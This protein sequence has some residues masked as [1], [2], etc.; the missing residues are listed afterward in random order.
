M[1]TEF[2]P[3]KLR[4]K[5]DLV[6]YP[7]RAE[8]LGKYD[9]V[10]FSWLNVLHVY[11]SIVHSYVCVSVCVWECV[12]YRCVRKSVLHICVWV[13]RVSVYVCCVSLCVVSVYECWVECSPMV[14]ETYV[15]SQVTSYQRLLKWYL[16][17]PC[18]T[19]SNLR[20]LPKVNGAIQGKE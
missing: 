17:P 7:A 3:V 15:Q 1:K 2:K 18:L 6:S 10:V 13:L 8:G 4:L 12:A 20:Y 14:R 11:G 19:L 5:I 9:K 16:I